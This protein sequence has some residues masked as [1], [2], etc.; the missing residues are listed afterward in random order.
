MLLPFA[1]LLD[2]RDQI[3][4]KGFNWKSTKKPSP[5]YKIG[6]VLQKTVGF[7]CLACPQILFFFEGKKNGI[8]IKLK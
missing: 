1:M 5:N 6:S 7:S 3:Y 8:A 2:K 4:L